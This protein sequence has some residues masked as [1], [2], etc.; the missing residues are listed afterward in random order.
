MSPPAFLEEGREYLVLLHRRRLV[1]LACVVAAL[2][3]AVLH[4]ATARPVYEATAQLLIERQAPRV[5]NAVT[6]ADSEPGTADYYETQYELLRGRALAERVL[7]RLGAD[8]SEELLAGP[9]LSPWSRLRAAMPS[10]ADRPAPA[11]D[12]VSTF[13]S[14][15]TV[16][17]LAGSRLVNVRFRAYD[18]SFATRA[19]NT[20][21]D[22]YVEQ[23][24]EL[25]FTRSQQATDWLDARIGE[26]GHRLKQAEQALLAFKEKKA[27]VGP[28][29]G[30]SLADQQLG[31]LNAAYLAARSDRLARE[32]VV[33]SLRGLSPAELDAVP[34]VVDNPVVQ[35]LKIRVA[36]LRDEERRLQETLASAT[37]TCWRWP[38]G[39]R[40]SRPTSRPRPRTSARPSRPATR[41]RSS[42]RPGWKRSSTG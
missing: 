39:G 27:M 32:V 42:R 20:L 12:L 4:N 21:A 30:R 28:G 26:Q 24:L 11:A 10:G 31:S 1:V 38:R 16:E 23:A 6:E 7:P 40:R 9:L 14:R 2:L 13:R 3:V 34:A 19:V 15:I 17:P 41:R 18:A 37:P 22:A 33:E 36:E 35:G 8:R 25:Q 29:S 5:L